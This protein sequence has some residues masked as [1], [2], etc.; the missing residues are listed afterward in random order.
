M[1]RGIVG[2]PP[3]MFV[4]AQTS[5]VC[6]DL[7]V[8]RGYARL[9][10]CRGVLDKTCPKCLYTH[11]QIQTHVSPV[12]Y[13]TVAKIRPR[14]RLAMVKSSQRS[15]YHHHPPPHGQMIH[16]SPLLPFSSNPS[17]PPFGPCPTPVP[18]VPTGPGDPPRSLTASSI[19]QKL[20][21]SL[22]HIRYCSS[23]ASIVKGLLQD[24]KMASDVG[25]RSMVSYGLKMTR[26][27][28]MSRHSS[29]ISM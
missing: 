13:S 1:Y 11:I 18:V 21:K 2:R 17:P 23:S 9:L 12:L 6:Y 15:I 8:I 10:R 7:F 22:I 14:C 25:S 27:W 16:N 20:V 19:Q 5:P 24:L 26:W 28:D 4:P 29:S 3:I